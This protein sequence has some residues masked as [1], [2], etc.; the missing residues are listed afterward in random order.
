MALEVNQTEVEGPLAAVVP[1]WLAVAG[2]TGRGICT[3]VVKQL[4]QPSVEESQRE[5]QADVD[6]ELFL[7]KRGISHQSHGPRT[8]AFRLEPRTWHTYHQVLALP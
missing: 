3:V 2:C 7:S 6:V 4:L 5:C 1:G 8:Y